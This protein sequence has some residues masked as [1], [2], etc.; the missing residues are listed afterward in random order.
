MAK[1]FSSNGSSRRPRRGYRGADLQSLRQAQ[2]QGDLDRAQQGYLQLWAKGFDDPQIPAAL[3]AIAAERGCHADVQHWLQQAVALDPDAPQLQF[4]LGMSCLALNHW[5]QAGEAF[6]RLLRLK[7]GSAEGHYGLALAFQGL[8]QLSNALKAV[9]QAVEHQ[10]LLTPALV[11]RA[12][13]LDALGQPDRAEEGLLVAL[14]Q[15]PKRPEL[16]QALTALQRT[17]ARLEQALHSANRALELQ[18]GSAG[19][20]H[21]LANVLRDLGRCEEALDHYELAHGNSGGCHLPSLQ[22]QAQLF[23]EMARVE[24]AR[25][26]WDRYW[27]QRG[28]E[29]GAPETQIALA[30]RLQH[31]E[32]LP[33][34]YLEELQLRELRQ[35][36][37][38]D[39]NAMEMLLQAH[40]GPVSWQ[41]PL[42]LELLCRFSGFARAYQQHDDGQYQQRLARLLRQ[43]LLANLGPLR[44]QISASRLERDANQRRPLRLGIASAC[45]YNHNG[46]YW[47]LGWLEALDSRRFEFVVYELENPAPDD[48]GAGRF[49]ALGK[50]R[51]LLMTPETLSDDL[52]LIQADQLDVLLLPEVGM[53]PSSRLLSLLRL[54][55]LQ[56]T[57]WGHPITSGSA[58][59]DVFLSG[60][61]MEPQDSQCH[62]SETLQLLPNLG[63]RFELPPMP[64]PGALPRLD[65]VFSDSGEPCLLVGC[66]QS[67][68]K[69]LPQFDSIYADLVATCPR[70]R[71][72][73]L[74]DRRPAVTQVFVQRLRGVFV[75]K[76]LDFERH[77]QILERLRESA[78][79][80][81]FEQLDLNL[82]SP[83]W[84]GG[85]TSLRALRSGCPTISWQG[86]LMRAR[87]TAAMLR[88]I[89]QPG[90]IA[91]APEQLVPLASSLLA[92]PAALRSL[93]KTIA[94][95]S[96]SL[97]NDDEA[98]LAF[99]TWLLEASA[100]V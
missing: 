64:D 68:F 77:V 63:F 75:G 80:A 31:L 96:A 2:A 21:N 93:R 3:A 66:V 8:E 29:L 25:G 74:A 73:F 88:R 81:L 90:L 39:L 12:E 18:P 56:L 97:F 99:Q 22:A 54:A 84:S 40:P 95:S 37:D 26:C 35:A 44:E 70:V 4:N 46:A 60:E 55:P 89:N 20:H 65:R 48:A 83:G 42:M 79:N 85:N 67:L 23:N 92:D 41:G 86:P 45:L 36:A 47:S 50:S 28:L 51:V 61:L 53:R 78:F 76:G 49:R 32:A 72:I 69:L 58:A 94:S 71:L 38:A 9:E 87:H 14:Q 10:P 19:H 7:P 30:Q 52:S 6:K 34:V 82:D 1:G 59:M 57:S 91:T 24:K 5:Q 13:L 100:H 27:Q 33:P 15:Q 43:L 11:L 98:A 17:Q 16:W 62:Y